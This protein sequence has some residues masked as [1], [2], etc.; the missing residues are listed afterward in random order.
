MKGRRERGKEER[1]M[2]KGLRMRSSKAGRRDGERKY[3]EKEG[4][5]KRGERERGKF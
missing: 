5:R 3:E 1:D 4:E 2:L